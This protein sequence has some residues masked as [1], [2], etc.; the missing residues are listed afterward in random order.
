M[1]KK[2]WIIVV[3]IVVLGGYFAFQKPPL[4]VEMT[5]VTR[6]TVYEYVTEDAKTRL[7]SEYIIDMPVAGTLNRIA[8]E[9]GDEVEAGQIIA[10]IDPLPLEQEIRQVEALIKKQGALMTGVDID[11]PKDEDIASAE[12]KVKEMSDA[13]S[14][15]KKSRDVLK[16]NRNK[17]FKGFERAKGLLKAGATSES[18]FDEA[19]LLYKGLEEDLKRAKLQ[20]DAARKALEQV[21]I[22]LKRLTGSI[23]DN[24]YVRDSFTAEIDGLKA[25]LKL[26]S[27]DLLKTKLISPVSGPV[28]EKYIMDQ[29]VL[30]AGETILRLGDMHSIEIEC[31]VLSEEV[32]LMRVGNPVGIMGKSVKGRELMGQVERIYPSG[33][34]KISALGVEQQR[35]RTIIAFDNKEVNLRPGTAVD[36]SIIT[37]EAP[38]ALTIPDRALFRNEGKWSL[39]VVDG[40][41]ARLINVEV[42]LRNDDWAEI[43]SGLD[44][45]ATIISELKN[46]LIDGVIVARLE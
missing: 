18:A 29:R 6:K 5:E 28:L 44:A 1:N 26:L 10:Y 32:T 16:I 8:L 39:F 36:V 17:A 7:D 42:G 34:M 41:T 21:Q 45:N 40:D 24:E 31:D 20:E 30:R 22:S 11:K 43:K 13:L 2:A 33:F 38:E 9:V 23:N 37:A 14:I 4:I 12:L 27:E 15:A 19:E 46:D 35:I 25:R 3:A